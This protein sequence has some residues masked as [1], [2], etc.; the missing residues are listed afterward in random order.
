MRYTRKGVAALSDPT[1]VGRGWRLAR[2]TEASG[3]RPHAC[4]EG[5]PPTTSTSNRCFQTP[6][7]WGGETTMETLINVLNNFRPHACGE[8]R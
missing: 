5:P 1:R 4:G 3:F 7:V 8:G 6:R 2:R